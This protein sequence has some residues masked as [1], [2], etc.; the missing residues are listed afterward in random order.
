M[1]NGAELLTE[2][3]RRR[4]E[5]AFADLVGRYGGLVF[6]VAK[7]RLNNAALAEEAAQSV[8]LRLAQSTANLAS[9]AELIGW[10]HRTSI[11]VAVDLW[12]SETRR[13]AREEKA[14][15]MQ[16][17]DLNET[18]SALALVVDEALDELSETDRQTLLLRFFDGRK[19]RELA[20]KLGITEDAA[21]MRVSRSLDRLRERLTA[22]GV[23][24]TAASLAAFLAE[25]AV[26]ALPAAAAQSILNS[27]ASVAAGTSL[28]GRL[29]SLFQWKYAA[30]LIVVAALVAVVVKSKSSP[31]APTAFQAEA[32]SVAGAFESTRVAAEQPS[33]PATIG[34]NPIQLLEHVARARKRITSGKIAF[35][36]VIKLNQNSV[37]GRAETNSVRGEIVFDGPRRRIEQLGY[38]YAY[39]SPGEAGVKQAQLIKDQNMSRTDATRAGLLEQ[40]EAHYVSAYDETA[41]LEYRQ[42][43][44]RDGSAVIR[45]PRNGSGLVGHFDPRCLGLR[46]FATGTVD[47]ALSLNCADAVTLVGQ[48]EIDGIPSWHVRVRCRDFDRNFWV[49]VAQPDRLIRHAENGDVYTSSYSADHPRDPLP[50]KVIIQTRHGIQE[51]HRT[52]GEYNISIDP[53]TFTLAGLGMPPGT[54]VNDDR[55][56]RSL[57]Y[58]TGAGLSEDFPRKEESEPATADPNAPTLLEQLAVLETE[59]ETETGLNAA[60]WIVFNTPDGPAIE[61]ASKAIFDHHLQST[62]LL[63]LAT[64]LE[65]LRPNCAKPL[66]T[67]LLAKNPNNEIRGTACFSLAQTFMDEAEFGANQKATA[68]AKDY[69]QRFIRDFSTAG[70]TAFDK[71]HKSAKAIEEIERGF[72]GHDAPTLIAISTAGEMVKIGEPQDRA[73]LLLFRSSNSKYEAEE[74]RSVYN[75]VAD[76]A[77]SFISVVNTSSKSNEIEDAIEASVPGWAVISDDTTLRQ[78]FY[79]HNWPSIVLIDKH[80]KIRARGLR[81]EALEKAIIAATTGL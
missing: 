61:K 20:E 63:T 32:H 74:F 38:E 31:V 62:N 70:K 24:T 71:K 54:M 59:P 29:A 65:T 81:G 45:D 41:I 79:V 28:I 14:A 80:G 33:V 3:R 43:G 57:G 42:H 25:Q 73:T 22:K 12:R 13:R 55:A 30:I 67:Q 37:H 1:M 18:P 15:A 6:S 16:S 11:H 44:E 72:L 8:F 68:Q 64:R 58:W 50:V 21:K 51:L 76:R 69:Y 34:A 60:L 75:K 46:S 26:T 66:L 39:T 9:E 40:F 7:R 35:E 47:S 27:G 36:H 48:E 49:S 78:A 2:F 4:S 77:V 5:Q 10:L 23:Q 19:M 56:S 52:A 53:A 17:T